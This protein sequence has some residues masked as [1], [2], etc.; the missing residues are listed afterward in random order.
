M[1]EVD[2]GRDQAGQKCRI[3]PSKTTGKVAYQNPVAAGASV[4][5]EI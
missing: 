5:E 2:A 4:G 1:N 3:N